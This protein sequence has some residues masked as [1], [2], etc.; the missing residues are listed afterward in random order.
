MKIY[1]NCKSCK[2]E[3]SYRTEATTRVEFAMRDGETKKINCKNCGSNRQFHVDELYAKESKTPVLLTGITFTATLFIS[4]YFWF[5]TENDLVYFA[6]GLPVVVYVILS[7]QDQ[8]RV[9]AFNKRKLKGRT[10]AVN[11]N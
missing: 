1:G 6:F 8:L 4:L 11:L 9:T 2:A 3:I 5:F 10:H 7:K